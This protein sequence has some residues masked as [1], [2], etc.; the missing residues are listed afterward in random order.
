MEHFKDTYFILH[1]PIHLMKNRCFFRFKKAL[2]H[3]VLMMKFSTFRPIH[4]DIA[5]NYVFGNLSCLSERP[6]NWIL[7]QQRLQLER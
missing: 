7:S 2:R 1:L 4:L 5:L 3:Q 6:T